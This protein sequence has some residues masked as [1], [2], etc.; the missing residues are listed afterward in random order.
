MLTDQKLNESWTGLGPLLE[1][2]KFF[3]ISMLLVCGTTA[4][5]QTDF[6]PIYKIPHHRRI[7]KFM[8]GGDGHYYLML[9]SSGSQGRFST[10]GES[11]VAVHRFDSDLNRTHIFRIRRAST[12]KSLINA[13]GA[14]PSPVGMGFLTLRKETASEPTSFQLCEVDFSG[15]EPTVECRELAKLPGHLPNLS[16]LNL[17][18]AWAPDSSAVAICWRAV[19][20]TDNSATL[21]ILD[22]NLKPM[23]KTFSP[24]LKFST[25]LEI[26]RMNLLSDGRLAF[27][28]RTIPDKNRP[29]GWGT[30]IWD[31]L[32][33]KIK[34]VRVNND[35]LVP[36]SC[37][38]RE[39]K[40]AVWMGGWYV[41]VGEEN[42]TAGCYLGRLGEE[43]VLNDLSLH[44]FSEQLG[45]FMV[46]LYRGGERPF[47]FQRVL[48]D[49]LMVEDGQIS[50]YWVHL[51]ALPEGREA[52]DSRM[53]THDFLAFDLR[54]KPISAEHHL[55]SLSNS[56]EFRQVWSFGEWEGQGLIWNDFSGVKK[57]LRPFN[58]QL[59]SSKLPNSP[60][61]DQLE[62]PGKEL[63]ISAPNHILNLSDGSAVLIQRYRRYMR[64]VRLKRN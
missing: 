22:Q 43:D 49:R 58:Y 45:D 56:E 27:Y 33:Q 57:T 47:S 63:L 61:V 3:L 42:L 50:H 30:A 60:L 32:T 8:Q 46:P 36:L 40:G 24:L 53:D 21:V 41:N 38:L 20:T 12:D 6:G 5:S 14:I 23:G 52:P 19:A 59:L 16:E 64:V 13:Y 2:R 1:M 29:I 9:A 25:E 17:K 54:K 31:P 34:E 44:P 51:Q 39:V 10:Y 4:V 28:L 18:I 37:T 7:L 62:S 35:R 48:N 15:A 11:N 55:V 26:R